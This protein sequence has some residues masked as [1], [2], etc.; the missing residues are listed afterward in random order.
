VK[1]SPAN[2]VAR[3]RVEQP[4]GQHTRSAMIRSRRRWRRGLAHGLDKKRLDHPDRDYIGTLQLATQTSAT[5][6]QPQES[7]A[8]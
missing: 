4:N 8:G 3:L 7:H 5:R 6:Q 1:Q 2:V